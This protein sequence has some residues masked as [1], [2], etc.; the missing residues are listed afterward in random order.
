MPAAQVNLVNINISKS[1]LINTIYIRCS[2]FSLSC[3]LKSKVD[4]KAEK[5]YD[6]YIALSLD[7]ITCPLK[8]TV[9]LV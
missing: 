9:K 1:C 3:H 4:I 7:F 5:R 2:T 8:P 6:I